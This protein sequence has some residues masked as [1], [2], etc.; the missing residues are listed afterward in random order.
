MLKIE[1]L[2]VHYGP[3][4][5]IHNLSTEFSRGTVNFI[6]GPNGAGKS[7]LLLAIAGALKPRSGQVI[8]K[9]KSIAGMNPEDVAMLGC[10][11][12]PEGR[13]V[14]SR[15]TIRENLR[16]GAMAGRRKGGSAADLD[17]VL[18]LFPILKQRFTQVAGT[19]SGGEQQQ[20]SIARALLTRPELLMIDEPSLGLAPLIVDGVYEILSQLRSDRLT[21]IIVEQQT[22]RV[23]AYG[24]T[25]TVIRNGNIAYARHTSEIDD[26]A[27]LES[28]Y[29]GFGKEH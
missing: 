23:K 18:N 25:V 26:Y 13:Q 14:F 29:F 21:M 10:S 22:T 19:L 11:L 5:A 17:E 4:P 27:E 15:L 12:V 3:V 28:A 6:V 8:F 9:G 7:S 24:D 20:L 2:A 1:N 16:L